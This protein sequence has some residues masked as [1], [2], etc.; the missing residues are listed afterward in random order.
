MPLDLVLVVQ[1]SASAFMAGVIWIVQLVHYPMFDAVS[2][3]DS[4]DR[5]RSHQS[6]TPL[7][8]VPP[9]LLE[10]ATALALAVAPPAGIGR[11]AAVVGVVLVAALWLSTGLVQMPLH[12]R[13]GHHGHDP[14]TVAR[15]VATNWFRTVLWSARAVLAAWMLRAAT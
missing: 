8:V 4:R 13:L 2:G 15:L 3:P 5:F 11:S 9:M 10:G 1:L 6:W 7:V 12:A 14:G